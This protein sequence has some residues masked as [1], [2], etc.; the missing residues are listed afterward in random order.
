MRLETAKRTRIFF[1]PLVCVC[2]QGNIPVRAGS[3]AQ[4]PIAKP[5]CQLTD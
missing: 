3:D 4:P 5:D 2:P 1:R